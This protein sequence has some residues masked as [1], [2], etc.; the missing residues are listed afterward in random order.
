MPLGSLVHAMSS[1]MHPMTLQPCALRLL[2]AA[3]AEAITTFAGTAVC[4]RHLVIAATTGDTVI[5]RRRNARQFQHNI[6]AALSDVGEDD[7]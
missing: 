6:D 4:G 2:E 5:S 7:D 1:E 3:R